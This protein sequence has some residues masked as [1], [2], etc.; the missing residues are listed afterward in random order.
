V[1]FVLKRQRVLNPKIF[2]CFSLDADAASSV[3]VLL[4]FVDML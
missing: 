1:P 4:Q 3:T 2:S